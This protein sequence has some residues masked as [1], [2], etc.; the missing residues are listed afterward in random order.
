MAVD[1]EKIPYLPERIEGL[2]QLATN[3]VWSWSRYARRIF[4]A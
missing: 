1:R 2:A 4:A 3:L